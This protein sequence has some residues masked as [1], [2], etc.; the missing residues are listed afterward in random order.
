MKTRPI[1]PCFDAIERIA[2]AMERNEDYTLHSV[3]RQV[4][5]V[6]ECMKH[7]SEL[8]KNEGK[9]STLFHLSKYLDKT[10]KKK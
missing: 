9:S 10:K 6:E 1:N 8:N 2:D 3:Y 4:R 5:D 7:H